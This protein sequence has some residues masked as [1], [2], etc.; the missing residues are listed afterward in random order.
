MK[1]LHEIKEMNRV[2]VS[3]VYLL[4]IINSKCKV[5]NSDNIELPPEAHCQ[6]RTFLL[7]KKEVKR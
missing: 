4:N 3:P 6:L 2:L 1:L 7:K 5:P